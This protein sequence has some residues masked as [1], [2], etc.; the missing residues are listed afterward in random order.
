MSRAGLYTGRGRKGRR[1]R[2]KS[3]PPLIRAAVFAALPIVLAWSV[4]RIFFFHPRIP[5]PETLPDWITVDLIP[6]NQWSRP[7]TAMEAMN[8]IV[9]HY[10]GNP[11]TTAQ[12]NRSYFAGLAR[13]HEAY[14]SSNFLIGL[15][16]EVLLCV[17]IGEVA[18]CSNDRNGDTLSI[19]VCHPDDTG[20]F[21][22]ASYESLVKLVN[23]LRAVY[24][25]EPDQ[26]IRHYDVTG[27]ECPR[28]YVEHPEAWAGFKADL[29]AA[30]EE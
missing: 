9:V 16:G 17:P 6:I 5:V 29:L 8:G 11:G 2:R 18:Y 23:W 22:P 30:E 4:W 7:G 27:K 19:E 25:L 20:Q 13:S 12:Q 26:V 28:Y 24:A 1:R 14:A 15:E 10:V 21:T 3:W